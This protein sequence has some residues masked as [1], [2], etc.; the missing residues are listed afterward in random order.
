MP[1]VACKE[2]QKLSTLSEHVADK[3]MVKWKAELE[4][5]KAG[6]KHP[7]ILSPLGRTVL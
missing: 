2:N 4:E 7:K 5:R 3:W 1:S 6:I